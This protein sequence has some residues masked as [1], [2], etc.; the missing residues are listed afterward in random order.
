M[1]LDVYAH[2]IPDDAE[3]AAAVMESILPPHGSPTG[4]G[5]GAG[6]SR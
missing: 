6:K 5:G 3:K 2:M 1:T 4:D